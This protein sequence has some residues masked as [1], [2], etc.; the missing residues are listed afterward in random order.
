[1]AHMCPNSQCTCA[2][3]GSARVH[4][5]V[6]NDVA[7]STRHCEQKFRDGSTIAGCQSLQHLSGGRT[8]D[9]RG[10]EDNVTD[11]GDSFID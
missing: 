11:D 8:G 5:C 10:M 2:A 6:I 3:R 1:M 4:L 7:E 9:W